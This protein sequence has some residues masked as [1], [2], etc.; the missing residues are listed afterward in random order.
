M[1]FKGGVKLHSQKLTCLNLH[2]LMKLVLSFH[3]RSLT[4]CW[5]KVNIYRKLKI[6]LDEI[7]NAWAPNIYIQY[8]KECLKWMSHPVYLITIIEI[9]AK[10]IYWTLIMYQAQCWFLY[11]GYWTSSANNPKYTYIIIISKVLMRK[12]MLSL[13]CPTY[14]SQGAELNLNSGI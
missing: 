11:R 5:D 6:V 10:N 2:F 3:K 9:I 13:P 8:M 7:Y 12:L 14:C 4:Q 1:S